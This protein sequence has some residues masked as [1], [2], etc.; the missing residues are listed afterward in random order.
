MRSL[1]YSIQYR[2]AGA[3]PFYTAII[4]L[5]LFCGGGGGGGGGGVVVWW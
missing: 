2:Y 4:D 1:G 5:Y 3:I